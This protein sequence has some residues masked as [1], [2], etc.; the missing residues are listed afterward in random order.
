MNTRH[1]MAATHPKASSSGDRIGQDYSRELG[2]ILGKGDDATI[3]S[4]LKRL[5]DRYLELM[6]MKRFGSAD[7]RIHHFRTSTEKPQSEAP[8]KDGSRATKT[9][10]GQYKESLV[11]KYA[12]LVESRSGPPYPA[13]PDRCWSEQELNLAS[14]P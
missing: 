7:P 5:D 10:W 8:T 3:A 2:L 1:V 6:Y 4:S 9:E 14:M 13:R 11:N 12:F